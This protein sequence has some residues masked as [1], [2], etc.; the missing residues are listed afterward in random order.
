M[1]D[2]SRWQDLLNKEQ[3]DLEA[4][5]AK[6]GRVNP[7]NKND[8]EVTPLPAEETVFRDEA[9]DKLEEMEERE[10]IEL[11]LEQRLRE[12]RAA[13]QRLQTQTFGRC[14]LGG[15]IIEEERLLVNPAAR[16]CKAHRNEEKNLR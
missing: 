14:E 8:W 9:G 10:E 4:Q 11:T 2:L 7:Q 16:T 12:V 6:L 3:A 1:T 15:E 5:L 13:L